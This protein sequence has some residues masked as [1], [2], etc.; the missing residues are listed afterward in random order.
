M[1]PSPYAPRFLPGWKL[2]AP[3]KPMLLRPCRDRFLDPVHVHGKRLRVL[4]VLKTLLALNAQSRPT[5]SDRR[6][7][8]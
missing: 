7:V 8:F 1:P 5:S 2:N 6:T 4:C 3:E